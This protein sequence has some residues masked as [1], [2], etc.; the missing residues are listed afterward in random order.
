MM[1]SRSGAKEGTPNAIPTPSE[2]IRGSSRT[3][4]VLVDAR[5]FP[6][7]ALVFRLLGETRLPV[8][9]VFRTFRV[10][11]DR[12]L[13]EADAAVLGLPLRGAL[14]SFSNSRRCSAHRSFV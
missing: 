11:A 1:P 4:Q 7:C 5:R 13:V 10:D 3:R 14:V 2:G 9:E 12:E 6:A 8:P